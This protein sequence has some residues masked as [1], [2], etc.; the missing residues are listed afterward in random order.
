[1][2]GVGAVERVAAVTGEGSANRTGSR[3][4][5]YATDLGILW[6]N[7]FGEILVAFGDSYGVDWAAPGA[8]PAHADWR[9]NV[10]AG[11]TSRDLTR[12]LALHPVVTRADGL[13][14]QFLD[15]DADLDHEVTVIP[16]SGIAAHGVNYV[17]YMSVRRWDTPGRW[18]TNYGGVAVSDDRGRTWRKPRTAR[19]PNRRKGIG[20]REHPFQMGAFVHDG[21]HVCLLGTPNGR[22][23]SASLA[24]V[25]PHR[26]SDVDSYEYWTGQQWVAGDPFA[27]RPVLRGP[28]GELSVRYNTFHRTWLAVH[29]DESR[30]AIVL[31]TADALNGPWSEP[32]QLVAGSDHPGL[33]G[34]YLHPWAMDGP[35]VYFT[36]SQWGPYQV[37]LMRATLTAAPRTPG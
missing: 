5:V 29:L 32:V 4:G 30:A 23:G 7:G 22:F 37:T 28:V 15:A 26:V 11:S 1:M 13:L 25:D 36:M 6:D 9:Y 24:R 3:F 19:W 17:H 10:L 34:G 16:T 21:D 31:R 8:G 33:Y 20:R 18:V 14:G 35:D 27:A 2:I 12:G